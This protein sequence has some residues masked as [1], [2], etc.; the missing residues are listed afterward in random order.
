[1]KCLTFKPAPI[2]HGY[3]FRRIDLYPEILVAADVDYVIDTSRGTSLEADGIRLDTIEHVLASSC[4][5]GD[6]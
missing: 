4:G 2:D 5:P 1:M 6:R 3:K